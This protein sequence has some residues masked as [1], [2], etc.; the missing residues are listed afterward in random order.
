MAGAGL[1]FRRRGGPAGG[2]WELALGAARHA[3]STAVL[4]PGSR[5]GRGAPPRAG[6][7]RWLSRGHC[8][9][10]R[11]RRIRVQRRSRAPAVRPPASSRPSGSPPSTSGPVRRCTLCRW[12]G[13]GLGSQPGGGLA[14]PAHQ[15]RRPAQPPP[16][17]WSRRHRRV[18]RSPG[19]SRD[20][21]RD[22]GHRVVGADATAT[23][24]PRACRR[25]HPAWAGAVL[26]GPFARARGHPRPGRGCWNP[27]PPARGA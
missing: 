12:A 11:Q 9:P 3:G 24:E 21:G 13:A 7:G 27:W 26:S 10:R 25:R 23:T 14:G 5:S 8:P 18:R 16:A 4:R 17:P 6:H 2:V 15:P 1:R 19:A 20:R 22:D